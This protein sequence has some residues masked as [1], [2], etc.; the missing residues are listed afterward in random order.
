MAGQVV[1]MSFAALL[2]SAIAGLAAA[3]PPPSSSV[4]AAELAGGQLDQLM[5]RYNVLMSDG[6]YGEA[7]QA[8]I[9]AAQLAPGRADLQSAVLAARQVAHTNELAA[10]RNLRQAGIAD[11]MYQEERYAIAST[12]WSPTRYRASQMWQRLNG[13]NAQIPSNTRI[14]ADMKSWKPT[15]QKI[16]RALDEH[17]NLEFTDQPLQ[18]VAEYLEDKYRIEVELDRRALAKAGINGQTSITSDVKG[19]T[20]RSA[21]RLILRQLDLKYVVHDEVLLITTSEKAATMVEPRVYMV[22]DLVQPHARRAVWPVPLRGSS[23]A[24]TGAGF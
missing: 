15:E 1:R 20:L 12:V 10:V 22:G 3:V 11:M 18:L 4:R 9:A 13:R 8:A 2:L 5:A 24:G 19:V 14:P 6:R 21:L 7:E 23:A 16:F 17:A